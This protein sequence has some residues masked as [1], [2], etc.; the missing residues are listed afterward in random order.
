MV[1][2]GEHFLQ[3]GLISE[4]QLSQAITK[5]RELD[6]KESLAKILVQ[7][8]FITERDR[9]R[10]LGKVWGVPFADVS[11]VIP[12]PEALELLSIKN[13]RKFKALPIE[14]HGNRIL[15]AMANPLDIFAIDEIRLTT[16][17]DVEPMIGIEEDIVNALQQYYRSEGEVIAGVIRDFDGSELSIQAPAEEEE[18]QEADD[19]PIIRLA[20]LIISQGVID[21]ASDIHIEP[22]KDGL[23][24]R[25]RIDGVLMEGMNLPKKVSAALASRFKII[26]NM[27]IAEKR[28]P[29]D[30]RIS[31]NV[32]GKEFDFRVSTL[33]CVYGEKIVMRVLDKGSIKVGLNRL[34][35]LENNLML[36]EDM[37]SKTYGIILVTGPTGSGKS[38]TLYSVLNHINTGDNNI[39]TIE[40]PVEYE[41][42]GINQCGVNVRAGMTFAAGLRAMLRQDPD[43]IMVGEMR[44]SETA[45]IAMEAALT[46]HL[47]LS[48]LHTNDAPSAPTRLMDM[49]VESFLISS[50][51][52]GILA[53]RLIRVTCNSCKESY[54]VKKQDVLRFGFELP[55]HLMNDGS[56][57]ITL[58]R[59]IGCDKCKRT[60]YKGRT[61][62]H[63]LMIVTDEIR[64][65]ILKEEAAHVLRSTAQKNGM[66]SLQDDALAKV[67]LGVTTIDEV[68]RVI[69]A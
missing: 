39:I 51:I 11:D 47:V 20:N 64:D 33:P 16:G 40:D 18:E 23:R 8:G 46:G 9:V 12:R 32:S 37:C 2:T 6:N 67:L 54:Q 3:E 30:N 38:T 1:L 52:I 21:K 59:G 58:Y 24:V 7:L 42:S 61:G 17:L 55:H 36:L 49:G 28:V 57:S 66:Q 50:S 14:R 34:G 10:C 60:G 25:Y 29:Q 31:M 27:D 56:D 22:Q 5:Q 15:V 4:D 68:V 19:A 13:A 53:Q 69:Y 44:D 35:L 26:A 41:L 65:L 48:T 45:T 63:E 62:I 43:V